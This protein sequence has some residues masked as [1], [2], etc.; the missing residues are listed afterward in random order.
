VIEDR[1]GAE[2]TY[3]IQPDTGFSINFLGLEPGD[4]T[5]GRQALP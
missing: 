3:V 1:R 5:A 4:F 2:I